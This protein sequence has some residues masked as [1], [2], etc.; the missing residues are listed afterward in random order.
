MELGSKGREE[1]I[2]EIVI[3]RQ[4]IA[5]LERLKAERAS[6]FASLTETLGEEF[7]ESIRL[8]ETLFDKA[9]VGLGIADMQGNLIAFNDAM[10]EPGGYT[11]EDIRKIGNVA[12]LY[13]DSSERERALNM[14]EE[15]GFLANYEV[16]FRKKD[17][18]PYN[19]LMSLT[20]VVFTGKPCWMSMVQD[21]SAQKQ[22][23]EVL[24][25]KN[26]EMESLLRIASILAQPRSFESK[27]AKALEEIRE[28]VEADRVVLREPDNSQV[29]LRIVAKAGVFAGL[30]ETVDLLPMKNSVAGRAYQSG[31]PVVVNRYV[32]WPGASPTLVASGSRSVMA[33]PIVHDAKTLGVIA[34]S[35]KQEDH[36]TEDKAKLLRAVTGQIG[37]LVANARLGE[38]LQQQFLALEK[39]NQELRQR[40]AELSALNEMFTKHLK[41]R[42]AIVE[43]ITTLNSRVKG[44]S[45][46]IEEL[47]SSSD[48]GD[49]LRRRLIGL[50]DLAR[51]IV[52]E[53][54]R[55]L[56][57]QVR[58]LVDFGENS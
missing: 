54:E 47:T 41:E 20:R 28:V 32:S 50:G 52:D 19:A 21:V 45:A 37:V 6:T 44:L 17:G 40:M 27:M 13:Y 38:S 53:S 4:R 43:S 2:D 57:P 30:A 36:F 8:Y 49:A 55:K 3:L 34:I 24:F 25:L 5:D 23:E 48:N 12:N 42:F 18:S 10:L 33:L 26:T 9:P 29:M 39:T 56:V 15:D 22:K 7:E 14:A 58:P 46:V 11:R 35:S 51:E 16:R 1:L 31:E